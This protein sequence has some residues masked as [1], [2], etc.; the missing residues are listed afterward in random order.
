LHF[1]ALRIGYQEASAYQNAGTAGLHS[2]ADRNFFEKYLTRIKLV[3]RYRE[4]WR[5]IC[6]NECQWGISDVRGQK[7]W[8]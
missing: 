3:H 1:P 2:D 7:E 4:Q 8:G 6:N 5:S